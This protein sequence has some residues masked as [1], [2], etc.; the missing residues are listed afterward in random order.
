MSRDRMSRPTASVPSRKRMLPPSLH[1]GGVSVKSRNC[2]LGECGATTPAVAASTTS[3]MMS[4]MPISAPR[5]REYEFQNSRSGE[6]GTGAAE[7]GRTTSSAMA[8]AR[9]DH[10]VEEVDQQVDH[11]DDGRHQQDSALH[12]RVVARLHAVH[13]PVTNAGPGK[14]RLGE[15]RAR[16]QQPDLQ[17]DHGDHRDQ[18]V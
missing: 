9:V 17:P 2:S 8:Y 3:A 10:A 6:G 11:D 4:T 14:D 12:D 18:R 1:A 16:E 7:G 5:L 13:Q 15:D